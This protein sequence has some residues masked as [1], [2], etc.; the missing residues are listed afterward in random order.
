MA[1]RNFV[2][3]EDWV[4]SKVDGMAIFDPTLTHILG[5]KA[6]IRNPLKSILIFNRIEKQK[7][8]YYQ[9]C[10]FGTD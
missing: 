8:Y 10:V 4:S 9:S 2:L 5:P 1:V 7:L 6:P 3:R